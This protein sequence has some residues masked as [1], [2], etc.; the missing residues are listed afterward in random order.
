[1]K[2]NYIQYSLGIIAILVASS[3]ITFF[4]LQFFAGDKKSDEPTQQQSA[5]QSQEQADTYTKQADEAFAAGKYY[6]ALSLHQKAQAI[7]K[8][9]SLNSQAGASADSIASIEAFKKNAEAQAPLEEK[10]PDPVSQP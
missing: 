4:A 7:Y 9:L 8:E 2:K 5:P 1:M 6:E 10:R 3:A